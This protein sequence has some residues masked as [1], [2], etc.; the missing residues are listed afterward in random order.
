MH[1]IDT[2]EEE[3]EGSS[4]VDVIVVENSGFKCYKPVHVI[5]ETPLQATHSTTL[6]D[7]NDDKLSVNT[8]VEMG[9]SVL[10]SNKERSQ[11]WMRFFDCEHVRR[12]GSLGESQKKLEDRYWSDR[13]YEYS[14]RLRGCTSYFAT[15]SGPVRNE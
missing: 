11:G 10:G 4:L 14:Y 3:P 15:P 13:W 8:D 7:A 1:R 12:F 6:S 5:G 9:R 2:F